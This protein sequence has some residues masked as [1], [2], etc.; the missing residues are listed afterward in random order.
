[1]KRLYSSPTIIV[2]N[3]TPTSLLTGTNINTNGNPPAGNA[4]S[5]AASRSGGSGWYD[6]D[7]AND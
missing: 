7:D 6:D 5:G 2:V 3:V 1:M 4:Y